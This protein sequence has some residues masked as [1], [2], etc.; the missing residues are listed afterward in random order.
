MD[1]PIRITLNS[2]DK[3]ETYSFIAEMPEEDI[4]LG[5]FPAEELPDELFGIVEAIGQSDRVPLFVYETGLASVKVS[6]R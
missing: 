2:P 6:K 1:K 5:T 4:K 3:Q